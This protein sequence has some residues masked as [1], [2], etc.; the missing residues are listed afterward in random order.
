M[1]NGRG[2]NDDCVADHAMGMLIAVVR[3]FRKLD[4]QCRAGVWRT[5]IPVPPGIS[6]KRL[7]ILGMVIF[8]AFH[9][10]QL[11]W[12]LGDIGVGLMAW[13]NVIAILILQKPALI[14][15]RDYERQKKLGLDPVF[16][17]EALGIR[18]AHFWKK[19]A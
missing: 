18:N 14:A 3:N 2:A 16:D 7:G 12:A 13:L 1:T 9:N 4:Q 17:P 15:L 6:G 5:Q 19:Q 11:A 8:G 10:A